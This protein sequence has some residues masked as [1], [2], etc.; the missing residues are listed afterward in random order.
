[1]LPKDDNFLDSMLTKFVTQNL[2]IQSTWLNILQKT[3]KILYNY[4]VDDI[5]K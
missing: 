4:L 5:L 3:T 2:V 1:M